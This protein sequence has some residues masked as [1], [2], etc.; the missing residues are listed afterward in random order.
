MSQGR[1]ET[2]T[3]KMYRKMIMDKGLDRYEDLP[4]VYSKDDE[5][6]GFDRVLCC[7]SQIYIDE[8]GNDPDFNVDGA[9]CV[10]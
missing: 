5:G 1:I 10:N 2:I 3:L 4:V 7:P 9:V 6:N 8:V